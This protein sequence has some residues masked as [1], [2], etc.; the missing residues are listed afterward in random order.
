MQTSK[1]SENKN[2]VNVFSCKVVAILRHE[3]FQY[4]Y[5][6]SL[7]MFILCEAKTKLFTTLRLTLTHYILLNV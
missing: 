2:R 6:Y 7:S 4:Y 5:T 1:N 3:V